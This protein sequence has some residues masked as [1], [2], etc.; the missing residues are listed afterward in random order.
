MSINNKLEIDNIRNIDTI[1]INMI[2]IDEIECC[3]CLNTFNYEFII[4]NCCKKNIHKICLM[5]WILSDYNINIKCSM[6]RIELQ[7]IKEMISYE[8]FKDYI[9][10]IIQKEYSK[11][12]LERISSINIHNKKQKFIEI[13]DKLYNYNTI[14]NDV[15]TIFCRTTLISIYLF[16]IIIIIIL[17]TQTTSNKLN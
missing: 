3:I 5:D 13:I 7:N 12:N 11:S 1:S 4:T 16:F 8:E 9:H 15:L 6:C 17:I 2:H 14:D 10:T